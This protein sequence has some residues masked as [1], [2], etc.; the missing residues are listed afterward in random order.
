MKISLFTLLLFG[1]VISCQNDPTPEP[2][3]E[4]N[5]NDSVDLTQNQNSG[6][7][8]T[9]LDVTSTPASSY[10]AK[11]IF[12]E[13]KGWGY[14]ILNNDQPY[15]N[16]PHIPAIPG[17]QGFDS[18]EAALKTANFAIYKIQNGIMPPTISKVELDS[19]G[20]LPK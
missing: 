6:S 18:E 19:L 20:V 4:E 10:S 7:D 2:S 16:Q 9:L 17:V 5:L 1:I 12:T 13:G 15:I 11:S 3:V 14:Q 8:T